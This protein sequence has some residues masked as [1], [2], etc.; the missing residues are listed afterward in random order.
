VNRYAD[1][2]YVQSKLYGSLKP[3][4]V[5]G[6]AKLAHSRGLQMSG[7]IPRQAAGLALSRFWIFRRVLEELRMVRWHQALHA[8]A[9]QNLALFPYLLLTFRAC[10]GERRSKKVRVEG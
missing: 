1:L 4:L 8:L 2:G 10:S 7:H 5:P 9:A 3:E 6:I